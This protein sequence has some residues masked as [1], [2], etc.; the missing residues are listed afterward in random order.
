MLTKIQND[1]CITFVVSPGVWG[2]SLYS[3]F[4]VTP[5]MWIQSLCLLL[6]VVIQEVLCFRVVF[7]S[8]TT[9]LMK[10][11]IVVEKIFTAVALNTMT[12]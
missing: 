10:I 2:F 1:G 4:S 6:N 5:P 9:V 12:A 11:S 3:L 8:S 7:L